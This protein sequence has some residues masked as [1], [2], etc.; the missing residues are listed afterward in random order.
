[1]PP[2][3][4]T[5]TARRLLPW[6]NAIAREPV[7]VTEFE[8]QPG[9]VP[10]G[11]LA[12]LA[13]VFGAEFPDEPAPTPE[14]GLGRLL[15]W[16]AR[17][18]QQRY[19][20]APPVVGLAR[21]ARRERHALFTA[22]RDHV[23]APVPG[24]VAVELLRTTFGADGS[25]AERLARHLARVLR[26]CGRHALSRRTRGV[27]A[28]AERRSM[29]W[30]RLLSSGGHVH[31][32]HGSARRLLRMSIG[33]GQPSLAVELARDKAAHLALLGE[34]GIPVGGAAPVD[35]A[36]SALAAA[37]R[38]GYPVALKPIAGAQG[39][40]VFARIDTA[41]QM[42]A[43]CARL[44][45]SETAAVVQRFFPGDDHRVLIVEGRVVAV[46][47]RRPPTVIG[48]GVATVE[49]LVAALN[50]GPER[51]RAAGGLLEPVPLDEATR[52]ALAAQGLDPAS[53]P[54]AERPVTLRLAANIH[55]GGT[56]TDLTGRIHPDIDA[57]ALRAAR[58]LGLETAGLD[59][60]S[61]DIT[62]SWREVP[63]GICEINA[64]PDTKPHWIAEGGSRVDALLLD[65][66]MRGA[67]DG[68]VGDGRIPVALVAGDDAAAAVG[69][70]ADLMMVACGAMPGVAATDGIRIGAD[71]ALDRPSATLEGARLVLGDP[72][73]TAALLEVEPGALARSGTALAR[74][75]VGV[76]LGPLSAEAEAPELLLAREASATLVLALDRPGLAALAEA[77]LRAAAPRRVVGIVDAAAEGALA[78]AVRSAGGTTVGLEAPGGVP[79]ICLRTGADQ[80]PLLA[81]GRLA[82]PD[83]RAPVRHAPRIAAAAAIALAFGA[84]PAAIRG[85]L[86]AAAAGD[87]FR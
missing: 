44:F 35:S 79:T 70:A 87:A 1:M 18:V 16:I 63:I 78:R 48:D 64:V 8:L 19:D 31:I 83:G 66:A 34:A 55:G 81:L 33:L 69:L 25:D 24:E 11:Q 86:E 46:A 13:E 82:G 17:A 53:V 12:T 20:V 56:A 84:E 9:T 22:W 75:D 7:A 71:R 60:I 52:D 27:V 51:R 59:V 3:S 42:T 68:R 6:H 47:R 21:T 30:G 15:V 36:A 10:K 39:K 49:A 14:A 38:I 58:L 37:E 85:A 61:P 80:M 65:A 32:G 50:A 73:V 41:E 2:P 28:E 74:W 62:R 29:P 54:E 26:A 72:A 4:L 77:E 57:L 67:G 76:L 45:E 43:A 40:G 5:V 23:F